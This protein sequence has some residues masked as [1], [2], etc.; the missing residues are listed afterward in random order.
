MATKRSSSA[1]AAKAAKP[2]KQPATAKKAPNRPSNAAKGASPEKALAARAAAPAVT[3]AGPPLVCAAYSLAVANNFGA[4]TDKFDL[5]VL[6]DQQNQYVA[7][8]SIQDKLATTL[9]QRIA[10]AQLGVGW[11]FT[12]DNN[13]FITGVP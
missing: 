3:P 12:A 4:V 2:K 11:T 8:G 1:K 7:Q 5:Q 6:D 10:Q 9:L 13:N